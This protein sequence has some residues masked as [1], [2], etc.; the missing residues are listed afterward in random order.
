MEYV[1]QRRDAVEIDVAALETESK[2]GLLEVL[3]VLM[4]T[5]SPPNKAFLTVPTI[6]AQPASEPQQCDFVRGAGIL[7]DTCSSCK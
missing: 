3:K 7:V 5:D 1:K 6:R 4:S 2:G